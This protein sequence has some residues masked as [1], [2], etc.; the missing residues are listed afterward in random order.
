MHEIAAEG[1]DGNHALGL[2]FA[3]GNMNRPLVWPRG[4]QAVI[5]EIDSIRRYACR[6]SGVTGR[7]FRQDRCDG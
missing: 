3:E 1:I 7:R 4:A 5:G 6:W 2:E